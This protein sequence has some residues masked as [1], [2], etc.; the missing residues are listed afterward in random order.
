MSAALDAVDDDVLRIIAAR[1]RASPLRVKIAS[2]FG[3]VGEGV[4]NL[5]EKAY[6]LLGLLVFDGD[7]RGRL[8]HGRTFQ[9]LPRRLAT[10]ESSGGDSFAPPPFSPVGFSAEMERVLA[11][12]ISGRFPRPRLNDRAE[13]TVEISTRNTFRSTTCE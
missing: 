7:P 6:D 8:M 12:V 3:H 1:H 4:G 13:S 9:P 2:G 5:I 10:C 11:P